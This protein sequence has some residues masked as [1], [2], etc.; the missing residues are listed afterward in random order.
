[1]TR[2]L[3]WAAALVLAG[4]GQEPQDLRQWMEA[5]RG[6][7]AAAVPAPPALQAFRPLS[8]GGVGLA[9]PFDPLRLDPGS[10]ANVASVTPDPRSSLPALERHPVE[11]MVLVGTVERSGQRMALISLDGAVHTVGVGG[12]LGVH[13][14]QVQRIAETELTLTEPVRDAA[15]R[16]STR[17]SILTLKESKP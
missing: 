17:T 8:Y 15:G 6:Q 16:R 7:A 4:C 12:R 5:Q 2:R 14:G 9:D 11:A 1:M 13:G 3:L 10:Y